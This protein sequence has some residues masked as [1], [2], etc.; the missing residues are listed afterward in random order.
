MKL[1]VSN[2]AWPA[3]QDA[4]AFALLNELGVGWVEIA[5]GRIAPWDD[6]SPSRAAAYRRMLADNGLAVS[7]LQ[8]IY[9]KDRKSVV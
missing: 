3:E 4:A 5:P 7:S 1:A 6:L 8:A 9:F 2:I